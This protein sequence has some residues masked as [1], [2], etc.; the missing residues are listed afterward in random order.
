[1]PYPDGLWHAQVSEGFEDG[2]ADRRFGHLSFEGS[3]GQAVTELL[4]PVQHVFRDAASLATTLVL[5]AI[6]SFGLDLP[7]NGVA[8][9]ADTW[10]ISPST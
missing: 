5:P 10:A 3:G 8:R 1:L 2:R 4:E 6:E 9:V 7:Q